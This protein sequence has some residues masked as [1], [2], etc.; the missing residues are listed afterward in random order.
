MPEPCILY[1]NP[2]RQIRYRE[3]SIIEVF[4]YPWGWETPGPVEDEDRL[5]YNHTFGVL[6]GWE[7]DWEDAPQIRSG[8]Q[9]T[10][11]NICVLDF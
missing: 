5:G 1:G 7:S 10:R 9:R 2:K 6:L 8:R 3:P 4:E 11:I